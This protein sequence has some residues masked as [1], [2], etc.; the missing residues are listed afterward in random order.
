[1]HLAS[2]ERLAEFVGISRQTMQSIV[3]HDPHQ[4]SLPRAETAIRLAEA[5]DVSLNSLYS[6]PAQCLREAVENFERAPIRDAVEVPTSDLSPGL[7]ALREIADIR[8]ARR[9][10][11]LSQGKKSKK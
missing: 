10:K 3:A 11:G 4:R 9:T 7:T 5:F 6:E 8:Q 1:M 2:M